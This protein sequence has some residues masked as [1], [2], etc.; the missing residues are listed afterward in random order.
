[1]IKDN[2]NNYQIPGKDD[3]AWI[4]LD[5]ICQPFKPCRKLQVAL[6][7][8]INCRIHKYWNRHCPYNHTEWTKRTNTK[9][10]L[11][12]QPCNETCP[13]QCA[14]LKPKPKPSLKLGT[15]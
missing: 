1:M 9:D 3:L 7:Q 5:A 4:L 6:T 13:K 2:H 11:K 14:G 8:V 15:S 12:L 10:S